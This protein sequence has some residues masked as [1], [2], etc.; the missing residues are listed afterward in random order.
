MRN[1]PRLKN[2]IE[3]YSLIHKKCTT[4]LF[5][6]KKANKKKYKDY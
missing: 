3:D 5:D 2:I 4:T 1:K 6:Y